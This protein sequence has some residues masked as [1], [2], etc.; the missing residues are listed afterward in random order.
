MRQQNSQI[1]RKAYDTDYAAGN[2]G[3]AEIFSAYVKDIMPSLNEPARLRKVIFEIDNRVG[4]LEQQAYSG[5]VLTS[6]LPRKILTVPL[7]A[8]IDLNR[9]AVFVVTA[10]NTLERRAVKTGVDDGN[11]IEIISGVH[12]G[13]TVITSAAEGLEE[14]MKGTVTLIGGDGK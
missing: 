11:Y 7:A 1:L 9:N 8:M 2:R 13:E 12:E 4:L 14:G 10:N 5:A 3:D 6:A